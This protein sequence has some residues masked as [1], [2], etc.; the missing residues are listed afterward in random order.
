MEIICIYICFFFL[1]VSITGKDIDIK[2]GMVWY[3]T[4]NLSYI[5]SFS[6]IRVILLFVFVYIYY[7]FIYL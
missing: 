4:A 2:I 7:N 5:V 6:I 1:A 3:L